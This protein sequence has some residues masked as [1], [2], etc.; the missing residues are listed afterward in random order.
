MCIFLLCF[1]PPRLSL[2]PCF[3]FFF[4]TYHERHSQR[5]PLEQTECLAQAG[6]RSDAIGNGRLGKAANGQHKR[7]RENAATKTAKANENWSVMHKRMDTLKWG[8]A[9]IAREINDRLFRTLVSVQQGQGVCARLKMGQI[10]RTK[11]NKKRRN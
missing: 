2:S 6:P 10:I 9:G 11:K 5:K 8:S 4:F 7:C 3:F 1:S